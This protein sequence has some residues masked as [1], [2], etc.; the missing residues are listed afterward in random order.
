MG[1]PHEVLKW[2]AR[3]IMGMWQN[4]YSH[5]TTSAP[6]APTHEWH[7]AP[8]THPTDPTDP[9][10][11]MTMPSHPQPP[12]PTT[13]GP[14]ALPQLMAPSPTQLAKCHHPPNH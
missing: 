10:R 2:V 12:N 14:H 1:R 4:S 6:V 9:N 5:V 13:Q 11:H 8:H 3:D 7:A